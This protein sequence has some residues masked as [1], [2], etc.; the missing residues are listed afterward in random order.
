M[1][2]PFTVFPSLE[3]FVEKAVE[4]GCKIGTVPGVTGPHG[5]TPIRYLVG[6]GQ[7]GAIAIL[8]NLG[9]GDRLA[10]DEIAGLVRV[11]KISGFEPYYIDESKTT[12]DY[13]Y[14]PIILLCAPN[15]G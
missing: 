13:E 4:Q 8:P 1:P 2:V 6:L 15:F 7:N 3:E 12:A 14:R 11:L 5:P 9:R 10:P